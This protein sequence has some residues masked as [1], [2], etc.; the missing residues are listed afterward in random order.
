MRLCQRFDL[1]IVI[2]SNQSH[3]LVRRNANDL[4]PRSLRVTGADGETGSGDVETMQK[5]RRDNKRKG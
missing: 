5:T 2:M 4:L 3:I 1:L